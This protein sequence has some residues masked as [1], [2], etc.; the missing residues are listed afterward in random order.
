MKRTKLSGRWRRRRKVQQQITAATIAK[1]WRQITKTIEGNY[2]LEIELTGREKMW[3]ICV[4]RER[5]KK[6]GKRHLST[7]ATADGRSSANR[8]RRRQQ[9]SSSY[10]FF[11]IFLLFANR[12]GFSAEQTTVGSIDAELSWAEIELTVSVTVK[13]FSVVSQP[14][15]SGNL[16]LQ[17]KK[18]VNCWLQA[19]CLLA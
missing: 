19:L 11:F 17:K 1:Y 8:A 6:C 12:T 3:P 2:W 13:F 14:V 18:M 10:F 7:A 5:Q 15:S 4:L 16:G 9:S